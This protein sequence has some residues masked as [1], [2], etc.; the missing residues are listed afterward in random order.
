MLETGRVLFAQMLEGLLAP[1]ASARRVLDQ[2]WGLDAAV[3]FALL[4]YALSAIFATIIP[5]ARPDDVVGSFVL[6]HIINMVV[7]V[8]VVGATGSLI[9][10]I[11]RMFGGSGTRD[12]AMVLFGWHTLV[13]VFLAPF[14]QI[15]SAA[16]RATLPEDADLAN[17]MPVDMSEAPGWVVLM[18]ATG[19]AA[20]AWLLSL[21]TAEL[22]GFRNPWGVL[23][24]MVAVAMLFSILLLGVG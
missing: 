12:Q 15:G 16:M 20:W 3:L 21:Y 11:G 6:L 22:H 9:W 4:A 17:G 5:G 7:Q 13:M 2:D 19:V 10:G 24:V 8:L 1:R 23:G 14:F 18:L